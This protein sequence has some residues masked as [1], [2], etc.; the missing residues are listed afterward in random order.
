M[1]PPDP[2]KLKTP[3]IV[4]VA[5]ANHPPKSNGSID[6]LTQRLSSCRISGGWNC[7]NTPDF[8][9]RDLQVISTQEE[10]PLV[11]L[12]FFK[13][14]ITGI[15]LLE[16][17]FVKEGFST[18]L[19]TLQGLILTGIPYNAAMKT[20]LEKLSTTSHGLTELYLGGPCEEI[21]G[22]CGDELATLFRSNPGLQ[23]VSLK[24]LVLPPNSIEA[25]HC[26]QELKLYDCQLT[27]KAFTGFDKT[28]VKVLSICDCG[29]LTSDQFRAIAASQS[30]THLYL[31][32]LTLS[33]DA[34]E[35]LQ[36][37]P[38]LKLLCLETCK[39]LES[40]WS[41]LLAFPSLQQLQVDEDLEKEVLEALHNYPRTFQIIGE[42]ES[43]CSKEVEDGEVEAQTESPIS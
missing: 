35:I 13:T 19:S 27:P 41:W 6:Q 34:F 12:N 21:K 33:S 30:L 43:E 9:D 2:D 26:V 3:T 20:F 14:K 29:G 15:G 10:D 16:N 39:N 36:H 4:G 28:G 42:N 18:R 24:D 1:Q 38:N 7:S 23:T 37:C 31:G 25:L 17:F 40:Q 11:F 5:N 32:L 22:E 8:S